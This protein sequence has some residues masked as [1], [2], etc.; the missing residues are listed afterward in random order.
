MVRSMLF[1]SPVHRRLAPLM[2]A[3]F[4]GGIALWVP[5]EKLFLTEL[6]FTPQL[7]GL[8]AATYA[9]VVPLLDFPSGVLADRWS[10]RGVLIVGNVAAFGSVLVGALSVNAATYFAAALLLGVFFAMQS[11]TADAIVYD[12]LLEERGTSEGFEP[13]LGRV[14]VLESASLVLGAFGGGALAELTS[15]RVTYA[16]TLPFLVIST[17]FLVA[18]REPHLHE[19]SD[20]GSPREHIA[21]AITVLR[22]DRRVWPVVGMLVL[23]AMLTQAIYEFGPLWLVDA[24]SSPGAFGPAWAGLMASIGLGGALAGRIRPDRP[25]TVLIVGAALVGSVAVLLVSSH[26]V[27]VTAAQIVA[28]T[29]AVSMGIWNT[30]ALH[31]AVPSELRSS[32]GSG[33]GALT[34]GGFLPFAIGFGAISDRFGI[35][36]AGWLIVVAS[37]ITAALLVGA[38]RAEP[39]VGDDFA[40]PVD[41]MN[42]AAAA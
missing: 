8:M 23:T 13:L 2:A 24:G 18:F 40:A 19:R 15:P 27:V 17:M 42:C 3:A 7:V 33:V 30:R 36:A 34:W 20:A 37:I 22:R 32:V 12:T 21:A 41:V 28:A 4:F 5:V 25:T 10:R 11:G 35:H 26:A 39:A 14:R 16:A 38:R 1:P 29:L 31:D 6:G 9:G